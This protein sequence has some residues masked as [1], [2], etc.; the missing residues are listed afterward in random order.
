MALIDTHPHRFGY[1]LWRVPSGLSRLV[2]PFEGGLLTGLSLDAK[3]PHGNEAP[4]PDCP[5][6]VHYVPD[7]GAFYQFPRDPALLK[8]ADTD[9][10]SRIAVTFGAAVGG[11]AADCE[12]GVG[13][14]RATRYRVLAIFVADGLAPERDPLQQQYECPL[15]VGISPQDLQLA[16]KCVPDRGL[17]WFDELA[18][19]PL[20][21]EDEWTRN[22]NA[23]MRELW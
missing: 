8:D 11:I 4:S 22:Y 14:L 3:C 5:C 13:C 19:T 6:G 17:D 7:L 1:K 9:M 10:H 15:S 18:A 2:S 21:P 12:S 20:A 16:V 23:A